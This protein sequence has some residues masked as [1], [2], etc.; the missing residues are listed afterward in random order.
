MI[1]EGIFLPL[2]ACELGLGCE[3]LFRD[4]LVFESVWA[5]GY[6]AHKKTNPPQKSLGIV[7]VKGP[8]G[9]R[10]F[11]IEVPLQEV[12]E[13]PVLNEGAL[14]SAQR[15]ECTHQVLQVL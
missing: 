10:S 4:G 11:R 2:C 3:E 7:I 15:I 13:K 5:Q 9:W 8:A 12:F 14:L 6:H 1:N